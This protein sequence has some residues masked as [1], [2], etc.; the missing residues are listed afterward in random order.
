MKARI[1]RSIFLVALMLAPL[2]CAALAAL[3][4]KVVAAV[5]DASLVLDAIQTFSDKRFA[6]NPDPDSQA[7]VNALIAKAR[8]AAEAALHTARGTEALTQQDVD[9]A[10]DAF[11]LAYAELIAVT[12]PMGVRTASKETL[13]SARMSA[14]PGQLVVPEASAL[15][16]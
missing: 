12:Q 2:G 10:F 5:T 11:K 4:P 7:K 14:S 1:A 3:L 8:A 6:Q 15:A 16:P 13:A 9:K